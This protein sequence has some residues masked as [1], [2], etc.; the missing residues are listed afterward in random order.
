[1]VYDLLSKYLYFFKSLQ[2]LEQIHVDRHRVV[3]I[4]NVEKLMTMQS[5]LVILV[6]LVFH[7]C[8]VQNV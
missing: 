8:V 2:D 7:L 1:M 3:Q 6:I 5:V 4:V